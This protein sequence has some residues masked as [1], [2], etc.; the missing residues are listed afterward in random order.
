MTAATTAAITKPTTHR[1]D[2][3]LR[4]TLASEWVKLTT[5]RST[6]IMLGLGV[7]LSIATTALASVA[8]GSIGDEWPDDFDPMTFSMVGNIFALIIYSV[9]GVLVLTREYSSGMMR[10]TLAASPQRWRV[11]TAKLMLVAGITLVLGVA[12][13]AGMSLVAR[14]ILGAY[15]L[16]VASFGDADELRL[17]LGLGLV[18][19]FFP[20]AGLALG[21]LLRSTAGA[22]TTTLGLLWLP[23][24]MGEMVPLWW[25]QNVISYLPGTALDSFT[26]GHVVDSPTFLDPVIGAVVAT[27]WLTAVIGAAAITFNRR[28]A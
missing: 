10:L 1:A 7:A 6:Y 15:G 5:L 17:V 23:V 24:I 13:T 26:I 12:T 11:L 2:P 20:V 8:M 25:Q 22:I 9:F 27:A 3:G 28:D 4:D 18:M 21:V 19:P 16:P 14:V